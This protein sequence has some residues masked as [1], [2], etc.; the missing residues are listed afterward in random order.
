MKF[1]RPPPIADRR[2]PPAM[3]SSAGL[4]LVELVVV[5]AVLVVVMSVAAPAMSE[6]TASNQVVSARSSFSASLALARSEAAK[7]SRPV[8]VQPL[9][10]G[11]EGN[12]YANGWEVV[13][14]EDASGSASDSEPRI[15]RYPALPAAVQLSGAGALSF[16]T[17][18][19][20]AAASDQV[21][22]VC[23]SGSSRGYSVT[24]TPSGVADV[25]SIDSC[26]S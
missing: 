12:E 13:V 1:F 9:S 10:G 8:I 22:T 18:G 16:R 26:A 25:A 2:R 11:S 4:T 21:F 7:R 15:R 20:L 24:V 19:A 6:F 23:R 3:R 17:S 14:D 5:M